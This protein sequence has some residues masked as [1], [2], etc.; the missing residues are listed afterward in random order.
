MGFKA[1]LVITYVVCAIFFWYL[2]SNFDKLCSDPSISFA[3]IVSIIIC[4]YMFSSEAWMILLIMLVA[5]AAVVAY[6]FFCIADPK[7]AV[8]SLKGCNA[9]M[10]R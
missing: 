7:S 3:W 5:L 4:C 1:Y 8:E 9:N 10:W 6:V 2:G